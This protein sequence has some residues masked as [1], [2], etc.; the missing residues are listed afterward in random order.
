MERTLTI[1]TDT[2]NVFIDVVDGGRVA[3]VTVYETGPAGLQSMPNI[4]FAGLLAAI[5]GKASTNGA[6]SPTPVTE[7]A[8]VAT[9]KPAAKK[10]GK[11][12]AKAAAKDSGAPKR[13]YNRRPDDFAEV[14]RQTTDP[15]ALAEHFAVPVTTIAGW[16]KTV[17]KQ[18][19]QQEAAPVAA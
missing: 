5:G 18:Q 15:A 1:P 17:R 3:K 6:A 16:L 2:G 14:A 8:P 13:T 4:D 9:T 11:P 10:T 7:P 12:R 19:E